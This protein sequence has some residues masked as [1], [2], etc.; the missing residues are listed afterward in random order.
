MTNVIFVVN[1]RSIYHLRKIKMRS[2]INNR[3][4]PEILGIRQGRK[5]APHVLFWTGSKT[6]LDQNGGSMTTVRQLLTQ[7]AGDVWSVAPETPLQDALN[8]YV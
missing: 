4:Y 6:D 3:N 8:I 5:A 7:K 1:R 2:T